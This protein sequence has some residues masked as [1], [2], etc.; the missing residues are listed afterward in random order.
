MPHLTRNLLGFCVLAAAS[1]DLALAAAQTGAPPPPAAPAGPGSIRAAAAD[2]LDAFNAMDQARFDAFWAADATLFFPSL[3]P[4]TGADRIE[5]KAAITALFRRFF[6]FVRARRPDARLGIE[7]HGL[8]V[9]EYG[10]VGIV[11]FH[12][13]DDDDTGRRTFVFRRTAGRWLI[14]HL[15]ASSLDNPRPSTPPPAPT[16]QPSGE[17]G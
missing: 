13:R 4:G 7:P 9:Q 6:D 14:A 5:G 16:P 8:H 15:H 10:D 12:L 2:F 1:P 17:R 11:T 3:A